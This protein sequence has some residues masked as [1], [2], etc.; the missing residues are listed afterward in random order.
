MFV[1]GRGLEVV[2]PLLSDPSVPTPD[3]IVCD[4]GAS[5]VDGRSL[6][7]VQPLQADIDARWP[8]ERAVVAAMESFSGLERQEV[9]QQ[10]RCSYFC[11]PGT[12]GSDIRTI[13]ARLG[14]EV[15]YSQ[16]TAIWSLRLSR[17][18]GHRRGVARRR[19]EGA[20]GARDGLPPAAV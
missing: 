9:P 12:V 16:P 20:L 17:A 7:P 19:H 14:C 8:G 4:V 15:L 13:A 6:Q 11:S 18:G 3:Y 1:T 10:R 2:I 5:V